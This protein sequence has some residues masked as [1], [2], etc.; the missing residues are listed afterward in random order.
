MRVTL[1]DSIWPSRLTALG[2]AQV[3]IDDTLALSTAAERALRDEQTGVG[4]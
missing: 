1:I 2:A 4:R 3:Q